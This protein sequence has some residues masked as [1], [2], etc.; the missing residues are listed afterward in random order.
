MYFVCE[1]DCV[2]YYFWPE[3]AT[4]YGAVLFFQIIISLWTHFTSGPCHGCGNPARTDTLSLIWIQWCLKRK[5]KRNIL[6]EKKK[7]KLNRISQVYLI[8]LAI[9]FIFIY[10]S[11]PLKY[12]LSVCEFNFE[13]YKMTSSSLG[14]WLV[15]TAL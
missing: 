14:F 4:V 2:Y 1:R 7:K 10:T 15:N 11:L 8:S 13:I 9:R 5:K 3:W 12:S 6:W